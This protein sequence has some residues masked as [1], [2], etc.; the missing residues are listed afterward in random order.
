VEANMSDSSERRNPSEKV[1]MV[2]KYL[3]KNNN[4]CDKTCNY[5]ESTGKEKKV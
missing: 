1:A 2:G 4:Q 3:Q 5:V